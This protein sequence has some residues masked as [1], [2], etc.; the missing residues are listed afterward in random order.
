[1]E[2]SYLGYTKED[3]EADHLQDQYTLMFGILGRRI[4]QELGIEGER[5]LREAVRRYGADRGLKD[6]LKHEQAGCR[7]NMYSAFNC[8]AG[9]P[10]NKRTH[11]IRF[12]SLE[13]Q[14]ISQVLTCPMAE[15]WDQYDCFDI[16]RIYCE[17]FHFAYYNTYGFGKT[18]V[19]LATTL[20]ERG[21]QYCSFN[22]ILNPA[23]LSEDLR[24]QCFDEYD[25]K[26]EKPDPSFF[27]KISAQEGYRFLY[28]RLYYYIAVTVQEYLG[29][30]GRKTLINGLH[31]LAEQAASYIQKENPQPDHEYLEKNY[32]ALFNTDQ[33]MNWKDYEGG[34]AKELFQ[35][36]FCDLLLKRLQ[37]KDRQ[38]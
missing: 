8:G 2:N 37:I 27:Q 1:M 32:P 25:E 19:N 31:E 21:T 14:H 20:T 12:Q 6:R 17:E 18:K 15:I 16:G 28:L 4:L 10:G 7:I 5:A 13:K 24:K 11:S 3:Y 38:E 30:S 33:E 23:D 26:P 34:D 29:E 22:V 35:T 9:L 36:D